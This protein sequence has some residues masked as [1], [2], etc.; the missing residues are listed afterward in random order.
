MR[1]VTHWRA[2]LVTALAVATLAHGAA[3]AAMPE[4][5][6]S[7]TFLGIRATKETSEHVD[8]A[9]RPIADELRR[10][11]YNCFRLAIND[12]RSV[13][14]GRTWELP[15][16]EDYAVRIQPNKETDES[17]QLVLSWIHYEK[18]K[19]G[20]RKPRALLKVPMTLRKG[21][22]LLSGGWKLKEGGLMGAVAVK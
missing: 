10:S 21:K 14:L 3:R 18:G 15:L 22:Y 1:H 2:A 11:K 8:P 13:A 9:L 19:D 17:V 6:I 7:V 5:A 20:K 4:E 16:V 12:T